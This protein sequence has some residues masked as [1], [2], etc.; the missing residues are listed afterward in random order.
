MSLYAVSVGPVVELVD[1]ARRLRVQFEA[2]PVQFDLH[3]LLQDGGAGLVAGGL[4]QAAAQVPGRG[5]DDG[6][7]HQTAV[8]QPFG[9]RAWRAHYG[10]EVV[11]LFRDAV[12]ALGADGALG[13]RQGKGQRSSPGQ[14]PV[15]GGDGSRDGVTVL[16][17]QEDSCGV[18]VTDADLATR[19]RNDQ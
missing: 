3:P 15:G 10:L 16:G 2:L 19:N 18:A 1:G 6:G 5:L 7:L 11:E 4:L 17:G 12:V 13:A 9:G 14:L 8:R